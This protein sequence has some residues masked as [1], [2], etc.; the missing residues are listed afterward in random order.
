M[1]PSL[2]R[3]LACIN[4][5]A[6]E[7][8]FEV[9]AFETESIPK[10]MLANAPTGF[11]DDHEV[12]NGILRCKRCQAAYPILNRIPILLPK[13]RR[14]THIKKE[15]EILSQYRDQIPLESQPFLDL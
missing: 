2:I 6:D 1:F 4:C 11:E 13:D 9:I 7:P 8:T 12:I 3:Y 10:E 5:R 15:K 14:K